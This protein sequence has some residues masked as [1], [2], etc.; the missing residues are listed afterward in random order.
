ME[1]SENT[2]VL[3]ALIREAFT[4]VYLE[5]GVSLHQTVVIDNYGS[6]AEMVQ[7]R[8]KDE[9]M[10]WQ[11]LISKPELL[12]ING[13]GGLSFYDAKGLRFHLPAYL[14]SVVINPDLN[15]SESLI[16]TLTHKSEYNDKRL[17]LLNPQMKHCI[18]VILSYFCTL[19]NF[20]YCHTSIDK[21]M[22][23]YMS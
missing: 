14:S 4:D 8:L 12:N 22:P 1:H 3:L 15:I 23:F 7:A 10:D 17:S 5:D 20:V 21:A 9:K 2:Q 13:I 6:N 16:F 18:S 19:P 11:K